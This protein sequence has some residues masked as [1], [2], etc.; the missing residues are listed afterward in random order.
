[1][2]KHL[3]IYGCLITIFIIYN[4]F[5]KIED[6]RTNTAINIIF[7]STIFGYIAYMAFVLLKRMRGKKK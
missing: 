3:F 7:A 5:F 4:F 2:K 6:P 1:M